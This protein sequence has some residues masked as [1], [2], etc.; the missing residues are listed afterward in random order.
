MSKLSKR[1]Q[2]RVAGA[3]AVAAVA[4]IGLASM[5][6][7]NAAAR[8]L[9]NGYKKVVGTDGSVVEIWRTGENAAPSHSTANNGAGRAGVV[10]G[11]YTAKISKGMG[12]DFQMG[13]LVGCQVALGSLTAGVT[14][15]ITAAGT[16]SASGSISLPLS[17]GQITNVSDVFD[18]NFKGQTLT[19]AT[20]MQEINVQGCGGYAQAR[21]YVIVE[22]AKGFSTTGGYING[23]G[24]YIQ[25]ILYGAPFSLN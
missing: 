14:G 19:I 5:G 22:A 23:S 7:G 16:P 4:S 2:R 3:A 8:P 17:P 24:D 11:T 18:Q 13:Y 1:V 20:Q 15:S 10:S 21:S 12:G 6:A 9:P 25:A